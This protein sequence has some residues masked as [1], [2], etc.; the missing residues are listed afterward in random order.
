MR[1]LLMIAREFVDLPHDRRAAR[2]ATRSPSL[3]MIGR[4]TTSGRAAFAR[5]LDRGRRDAMAVL[6][7]AWAGLGSRSLRSAPAAELAD[8]IE[9]LGTQRPRFTQWRQ[10]VEA[11]L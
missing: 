7:P 6:A 8:H 3:V 2:A 9:T 5:H 11:A 10:I 1:A 4:S